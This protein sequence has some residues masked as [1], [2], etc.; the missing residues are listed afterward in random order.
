MKTLL[1][2]GVLALAASQA[3]AQSLPEAQAVVI[4]EVLPMAG[5]IAE[6]KQSKIEDVG[7]VFIYSNDPA[8]LAAWYKDKLGIELVLNPEEGDYYF[9]FTRS[10]V[11][12]A[13]TVFAIKP[14]KTRLSA[15]KNQFSVNFRISDFEAFTKRLK[16][17]GVAIERTQDYPGFGTFVW[18]KDLEGNSIEFW[19]PKK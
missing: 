10:N 17:K 12:G 1:A 7:G 3:L 11:P 18:I 5:K 9:V 4:K 8:A 13:N 6:A 19:Q 16:A 2:V 14:A 15:E